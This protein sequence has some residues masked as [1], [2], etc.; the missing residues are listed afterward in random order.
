M[1]LEAH[2]EDDLRAVL[3]RLEIPLKDTLAWTGGD[4][5]RYYKK[6]LGL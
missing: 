3:N 6:K 2:S 4:V 1:E 5:R